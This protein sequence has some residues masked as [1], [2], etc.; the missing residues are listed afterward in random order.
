MNLVEQQPE[1][2]HNFRRCFMR[3]CLGRGW[4]QPVVSLSPDG[5]QRAYLPLRQFLICDACKKNIMLEDLI[6]GPIS[7]GRGAWEGIQAAFAHAG[8]DV[9]QQEFTNLIWRLA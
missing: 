6:S 8:K 9:P 3:G 7:D 5:L 2:L 4:W 1:I